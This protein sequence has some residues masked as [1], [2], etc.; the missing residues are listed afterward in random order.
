V[1]RVA[2]LSPLPPEASGIADYSVELLHGL[3]RRFEIDLFSGGRSGLPPALAD[4]AA[5]SYGTFAGMHARRPYDAVVYHL[6]NNADFHS[7]IYRLALRI[8][9]V[10]VLHEYMLHH[11]LRGMGS[12]REYIEAM[13]YSYGQPGAGVARRLLE[14]DHPAESWTYPLFEPVVDASVRV[15]VHSDSARRRVLRSR[16]TARVAVVPHHLS[17]GDLPPV[18]GESRAALRR[19]LGIPDG[20][21]ILASFGNIAPAK[22]IETALRAFARFRRTRPGSVYV[23]AGELS[24]AYTRLRE[25]L[26]GELGEGVVVTGR[27]ALPRLLEVMDLCDVAI[28]LRH[29]DGG[30]TSGTCVRLLGLGKPVI[31]SESGWFSDIPPGCCAAVETGVLEEEELL[32]VLEALAADPLLRSGMGAAARRWVIAAHAIERSV[33]LYARQIDAA[34]ADGAAAGPAVPPLAPYAAGDVATAL[35][36]DLSA[37]A[38]DLGIRED[39]EQIL[40]A[41]ARALVDAGLT[42]RRTPS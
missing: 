33:D 17:L 34:I 20:A 26:G 22:R 39:D 35:L 3:R 2:W 16:P 25:I 27:L 1:T 7:E 14:T 23:L 6:G 5:S 19:E 12:A 11:L 15:I 37:A 36:A 9:G 30:E 4:L 24:W 28:N 32:A 41:L 13:R 38:G 42:S 29:P 40:P 31:V 18:T 10:V 8:P 21:M